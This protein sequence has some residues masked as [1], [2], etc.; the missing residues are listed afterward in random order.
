MDDAF[1]NRCEYIV[2]LDLGSHAAKCMVGELSD[3]C[4]LKVIGA[5]EVVLEGDIDSETDMKRNAEQIDGLIKRVEE[6]TGLNIY[7]V[8]VTAGRGE[9]KGLNM[10]GS[11]SLNGSRISKK[12][13]NKVL[14]SACL[15]YT[16]PSPRDLSTSR[17]P[18]SA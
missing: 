12:H 3:E 11:L 8:Y 13:C 18:S 6:Q 17:M 14:Q 4:N 5:D 16:S 2:G 7:T 1:P 9:I 10:T 15:L